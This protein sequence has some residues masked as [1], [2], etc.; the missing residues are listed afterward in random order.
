MRID[1]ADAHAGLVADE[2]GDTRHGHVGLASMGGADGLGQGD[3]LRFTSRRGDGGGIKT[4]HLHVDLDAVFSV[5]DELGAVG[6][7]LVAE[8][9]SPSGSGLLRRSPKGGDEQ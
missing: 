7:G 1:D 6:L 8:D 9:G 4:R 3:D 2:H 5:A